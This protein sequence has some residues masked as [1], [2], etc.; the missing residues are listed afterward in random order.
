MARALIVA[1]FYRLLAF[2]GSYI[3]LYRCIFFPDEG[4]GHSGP[5]SPFGWVWPMTPGHAQEEPSDTPD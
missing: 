5:V 2:Y 4:L 3:V 1:R